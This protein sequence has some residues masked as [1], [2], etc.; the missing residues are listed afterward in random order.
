MNSTK[1]AVDCAPTLADKRSVKDQALE[2]NLDAQVRPKARGTHR[3][4]RQGLCSRKLAI[5]VAL[6]CSLIAMTEMASAQKTS[7]SRKA[8]PRNTE[9]PR[10]S[11]TPNAAK[12][13]NKLPQKTRAARQPAKPASSLAA[14]A[15]SS[16]SFA[17]GASS[18]P[19][20][21][22]TVSTVI[23]PPL[24]WVDASTRS[25]LGETRAWAVAADRAFIQLESHFP[26]SQVVESPNWEF[27][28]NRLT[29]YGRLTQIDPITRWGLVVFDGEV[30]GDANDEAFKKSPRNFLLEPKDFATWK[31]LSDS[32][33]ADLRRSPA[34]ASNLVDQ[35][36]S[37]WDAFER[38]I[39]RSFYSEYRP[40]GLR[41]WLLGVRPER[42]P[43]SSSSLPASVQC[44]PR[45]PH[46][47]NRSPVRRWAHE[48]AGVSCVL[49]TNVKLQ[50]DPQAAAESTARIA[51]IGGVVRLNDTNLP[52]KS[53]SQILEALAAPYRE[54]FERLASGLG[55]SSS[56]DCQTIYIDDR[57]IV[58]FVCTRKLRSPANIHHSLVGWGQLRGNSFL[59]SFLEAEGVSSGI[60][61]ELT[62]MSMDQLGKTP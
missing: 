36:R 5:A 4:A 52:L 14:S 49:S 3:F 11:R 2:L 12:P 6:C 15:A 33:S 21:A 55:S 51:H 44:Q 47:P 57:Q 25:S 17:G 38:E 62:R 9:T 29:Y 37:R 45:E 59:H 10:N 16:P 26:I 48:G 40:F 30:F 61:L 24:Q 53:Q 22:S 34:Q 1:D 60:I 23:R 13:A 31:R 18:G 39:W 35:V 19:S 54:R 32:L 42:K 7:P 56:A 43:L 50:A 46:L 41:N 27:K 58:S 8:S 28:S 20:I